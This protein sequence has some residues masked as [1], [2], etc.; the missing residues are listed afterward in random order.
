MGERSARWALAEVY[1][2]KRWRSDQPVEWRGPV[3][4]SMAV[5]KGK[6]T[7]T[8]EEGDNQGLVL[9]RN[10]ECG[11]YIAGKW[12]ARIEDIVVATDA[13]PR[14]L[15]TSDHQLAIVEA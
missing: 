13:G 15:N 10:D 6:I 1:G 8:F 2:V 14:A 12:G 5:E 9:A 11:F 7:V 3:Y 4:K